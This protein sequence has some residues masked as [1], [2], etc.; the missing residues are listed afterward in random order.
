MTLPFTFKWYGAGYTSLSACSNGWIGF[1]SNTLTSYSNTVLPTTTFATPTVFPLWDDQN[2]LSSSAPGAWVG[3]YHDAAN[4]RFIVEYDSVVFYGTST[5]LKYE[6]IY[7]DSTAGN[8]CY[9]AVVQYNLLSDRASSSVGFQRNATVGCQLLFNG[10]YATTMR[11]LG[12][13]RAVRITRW[14]NGLTGVSEQPALAALPRV[15]GLSQSYPNPTSD[16]TTISYQLPQAGPVE[17]R[18]Y[19]VSGQLVRTLMN[20][21]RPAGMHTAVWDGRDR[22]G[23]QVAAGIYLYNLTTPEY[24]CTKKLTL[25]R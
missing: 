17:L 2:G 13:G 18:V 21:M 24:S 10:T 5:R 15:F 12:P 25:V 11:P 7:Y 16:R 9:D 3:Y 6:V 22:S 8:P 20:G 1:G 23:K 4:G 19:N 14:P